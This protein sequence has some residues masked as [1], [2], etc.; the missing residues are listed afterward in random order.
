MTLR[1]QQTDPAPAPAER[2][3]PFSTADGRSCNVVNVR[4]DREP[5]RGPVLLVHGA[6]VRS[7]IFR[8]PTTTNGRADRRRAGTR[9]VRRE[10]GRA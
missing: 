6:G 3:V 2:V 9:S 8:A 5:T 7:N 1:P 4:G 10:G